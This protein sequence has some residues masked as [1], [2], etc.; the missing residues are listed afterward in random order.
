MIPALALAESW[1]AYQHGPAAQATAKQW[2]QGRGSA[3][4]IRT[5]LWSVLANL[6]SQAFAAGLRTAAAGGLAVAVLAELLNQD[7]VSSMANEWLDEVAGT[8]TGLL[9]D[10]I[11]EGGTADEL[12][13]R[14]SSV[15]ADEAHARMIVV[16]ET[17][18]AANAG[19]SAGYQA[20]NVERVQWV[21]HSADPC[22]SCIANE[23]QGPV[24]LGHPFQSGDTAP[25]A[26]PNCQ[27]TLEPV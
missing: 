18:R 22:P 21:T 1:A 9:A 25:P 23:K 20:V 3:Q 6:W 4:Q 27:C 26:H 5:A 19:R 24:L 12:S 16:T 10:A 7:A 15:L 14:I 17:T 8:Y 13:E 11:A 2:L